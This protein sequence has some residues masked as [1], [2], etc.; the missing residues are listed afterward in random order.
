MTGDLDLKCTGTCD[1]MVGTD[2]TFVMLGGKVT[3]NSNAIISLT[4]PGLGYEGTAM[5][6][7]LF[8]LPFAHYGA[9]DGSGCGNVTQELKINGNSN[10]TFTGTILAPCSDVSIEGTAA[11]FMFN[12]Q[13]IGWNVNAGGTSGTSVYYDDAV[14]GHNPGNVNLFR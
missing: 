10:N 11:S 4:A 6:G 8:Y 12:S 2:V 9:L 1:T 7:I 14:N 13:V 5:P 3:I